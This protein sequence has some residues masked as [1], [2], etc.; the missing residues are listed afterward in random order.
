M[1]KQ[2][3]GTNIDQ[4]VLHVNHKDLK[5]AT[6]ESSI[7]KAL[8]PVCDVG[9]LLVARNPKPPHEI[10]PG[11]N[12]SYCGQRFI[13]RDIDDLRKGDKRVP[14]SESNPPAF[15]GA[16]AM[17]GI[18]VDDFTAEIIVNAY[19]KYLELGGEFSLRD[20]S[21]IVAMA[22]ENWHLGC[23]SCLYWNAGACSWLRQ[24]TNADFYCKVHLSQQDT[25]L[26]SDELGKRTIDDLDISS[27]LYE[28]LKKKEIKVLG[29]ILNTSLDNI[30]GLTQPDI[31]SRL[32]LSE[33]MKSECSLEF[34]S[35]S[36]VKIKK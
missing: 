19:K 26:I 25:K 2:E 29:D 30:A 35:G 12:C 20:S 8:C 28:L 7:Y 11:D 1:S 18:I 23:S 5:L 22:T 16:L 10:M 34:I 15:K 14:N 21:K 3:L 4:P 36:W 17:C 31:K 32:E 6:P 9:W 33:Y 13:Y 27:R 24:I